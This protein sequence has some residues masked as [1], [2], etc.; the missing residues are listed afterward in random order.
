[1]E[2]KKANMRIEKTLFRSMLFLILL[3]HAVTASWGAITNQTVVL[4]SD[5]NGDGIAGIGDTITFTCRSTTAD[6]TQYPYVNLSQFGNPYFA[7]P[8]IAGTFY[9]AFL[10]ISPG[11]LENNTVQ[12]FQFA[13]EDGVRIGGSLLVDN[14]RPN[15]LYGPSSTGET[16]LGSVFK[17][18]DSLQI[19][20]EMSS[21]FDSDA[22]RANLTNIGL[23]ASHMF[24]RIGGPDSAPVYRL[25]LPFPL[26]REGVATPISV[27]STDDAGNSRSW[28]LSVSYDTKEPEIESVTAVNMTTGKTWVTSGDTIR[29]QA[30]VGNYDFDK[31]KMFHPTLAPAGITMIKVSG[32]TP[33]LQAVYQY[34]YYL[35]DVPDIQ[36]NFVTFEVRSTDDAGNESS[37]RT[38]N[39]LALDNIPP[40]FALPFGVR[41]V[42]NG[43]ILGDNI[44]IIN[45]QLHFVGNLS[46]LMTDVLVTVDLSSIGGVPNQ[47]IP[48]NNSATT[49]F[50][51]LYNVGQYT[52]ENSMPRAFT[53]SA[54]DTAGN[55]IS[56]IILPIIYVDN[57]PPIMTGGQIQNVSRPG[58]IVRHGDQVAITSSVTNLD[59]GNVWVNFE[60]I[61]GS[62]VSALTPYSGT[63]YRLDHVV[64]DPT[65]GNIY[66][67]SVSFTIFATDDSGN[68]VQVIAPNIQIDNEPPLI[69]GS[70][71]SSNPVISL[72]HPYVRVGDSINFRVQL[73]S[74]S[75]S[76]HDQETVSMNL[77]QF[78]EI[79][80]TPMVYDGV[81]SYTLSVTVPAGTLNEEYYFP[82]TATDNAGNSR[83]GTI[84]VKIDNSPPIVGPMAINF[85]TDMSK[86][87]A[88]N[89]GDRLEMIVPVNEPDNGTCTIDLSYI[90]GPSAYIMNYDAVLRRYYLVHDCV[91]SAMENPS[92]VFR[93]I[94]ADKAGNTMNSVSSTF[95]VDCR[96]PVIEYA[97][98]THLELK[99]KP[100]VVNIGDKVRINAK[101]DLGRLDGGIPSV[102][103][104][105]LG[106][107]GV[108]Q[109]FDDGANNDGIAG[110]GLYGYTFTAISGTT[111]GE[112]L[113]FTVQVTDNAG[114]RAIKG[115]EA[116]FIDNKPLTITSITNTQIF[117]N[118]GNSIV[119]LDGVYTTSPVVATDVVR[120]EVWISGNPGD[121]GTLTV[122][123][124][125]LGINNT[126]VQVPYTAISGGWKA[127]ADYTPLTGTTNREEVKLNTTL[128]DVNGNEI[129]MT[130]TNAITVDNR[131]PKID[132]YPISFVVDNGR[133]N[134]GNLGDVVQ[135]KVRLT[136]HNDL[137][138]QI[139]WTNLYLANGLTPPSPTLMLPSAT[140]SN[141][142]V[143]QWT[144]PE[145]LGTVGSLTILA[146]DESGNMAFSYTNEIRFLSKTPVFAGFPQTRADL[147]SDLVPTDTPNGIANPGDQVT[148]TCVLTSLYNTTNA[149]AA[150]VLANVRSLINSPADDSASAYFD[151][152]MRTYWVPLTF[153]AFPISGAGNYVY[154]DIFNITAGGVD[155]D[156]ASFA[157]K[158][159][160]PD[161][162]S[163]V[164]ATSTI[165]CDPD[166]SFGIDTEVPFIKNVYFSIVNENGDN[167]ASNSVNVDD[168]LI[169]RA[170]I[171]KLP[172]PGSAT[173][174]LLMPDNITEV[175]R[176]EIYPVSTN[177]WEAQFRV[178]TWTLTGWK[179]MNGVTPRFQVIA[180]DDADN[181]A[182][183][184]GVATFTIDN[185]PPVI[186]D[187][188]LR[189]NDLNQDTGTANVGD[190]ITLGGDNIRPDGIVASLTVA[191]VGDLAGN[192]RAYVDFTPI[193]GTSTYR[194]DQFLLN[195]AYGLPFE[196]ATNTYDLATRTFKIYVMDG[197]GNKTY[198]ERELGIDT[199]RPTL[200][201]ARYDGA[202]IT[203]DFSEAVRPDV[204]QTNLDLIRLG[205]KM[206]HSDIQIANGS[207]ISL[208]PANDFI[209]ELTESSSINI[210]L[211]SATKG[212]IA[213]WGAVNLY[214][215]I[216][217]NTSNGEA[218]PWPNVDWNWPIT[219]DM[220]GNW[221]KPI[222]RTLANFPIT[223]TSTYT[224]R[225]K[226]VTASHNAN[227]PSEKD[228]LYIT[229]D[230]DMDLTSISEVTL[231]NLAIWLNRSNPAD[232][233]SN[234]Y[235]FLTAAASDTIVGLD[236]PRRLKLKLSEQAQDWIAL[237][238]TRAG[239]QFHLQVNGSE[240]EP[241]DPADP[242]PLIR[243]FEGN[244]IMPITYNNAT[245]GTLIPLNTPFSVQNSS[246]D[247]SGTQPILRI[248]FQNTPARK[249]R[250]F[251]DPYK[252]LAETIEL[253]RD[254][255][256]D[257]SRIY[258]HSKADL[259]GS[260]IPLSSTMVDYS[261]FKTM[262]TDYASTT[263]HIPLT[264]EALK[265]ML[266][267]GTSQFYIA[268]SDG[269][270]RDLWSNPNI[271]YPVQ[272]N[273]AEPVNPIT[274]PA[275]IAQPKIQ[276]IAISPAKSLSAQNIQLFKGQPVGNFFYE[277]AFETAT[278][279]ADVYI[280]IDRTKTPILELF[281][282]DD[283]GFTAPKDTA[284]FVTWLDHNQGGVTRTVARFAN[285]SDLTASQNVQ[286]QPSLVRV[287][288]FADVFSPTTYSETA[289][290][291]Y[292]LNDKDT[293][294]NGFKNASY[295]MVFDNQ[296]PTPVTA[297]PNGTVGITP[298]GSMLFEVTFD[299][300]MDNTVGST[301]QPQLRLGDTANTVMSFTFQSWVS[302][303]TA[304]FVNSANFDAN[305]QQGT[306]TYFVSGGFDEAGNRGL[307]EVQLASQLQIRSKGPNVNSFR[308]TTYQLTTAKFSSPTGDLT[309]APFSPYVP[310][311]IATISID[312]LS[313]PNAS[314][315]W[316]HF[317]QGEASLASIPITLTGLDGKA[318]WDGTF[319]GVPIGLT[320]PTTYNLRVYDDA[321]N[322][323]SKRGNI[324]YDG[325]APEVS[326]W[327]FS[328]VK[329]FNNK[330]YFS[331]TISSFAKIDVFGPSS[332]QALKMR[333]VNPGLATD[334]YPMTS[335][336]GGG[337][338]ISFDGK[339]TDVPAGTLV[340][341]EYAVH[342]VDQAGNVGIPLGANGKA[343]S[344]LVIDRTAPTIDS[345]LMERVDNSAVVTRFNPRVT[346]LKFLVASTD[347]TVAS[348]T[349]L[350]KIKAGSTLIR[351]IILEEAAS[352]FTAIWNGQDSNLQPVPDG[353][354]RVTITDLAGNE[355]AVSTDVTVVNSVFKLT[356]VT[357]KDSSTI[358]VSF[359]HDV[360]PAD[361][362]NVALYTLTPGTPAGIGAGA[363]ITVDG[364]KVTVPLTQ[365]LNHGTL[366]TLTLTPGF[367]SVDDEP[368][369]A[370]NN[371]A[372]F[373]ADT[374]GPRL[375]NITYDGLNSQKK[376]N[377]VFDEQ[378]ESIS[379]QQVGNF[380][381]TTGTETVAIESV[382]LRADLKSVTITSFDD[383]VE[384]KNYT[385]VA[386]GVKDLFGNLSDGA[387]ARLTFQGKDITPPVLI[388]SAFSNPAN[389]FDISV[390]VKANEDLSGAP[391]ATITQSGGTAVSLIL[392][393]GPN[394]RIFIGGAHL[395]PNYPGVATIKV[396][397]RDISTNLGTANMSFSTAYINASI[398]AEIKSP[399]SRFMAVFEPGTLNKNTLVSLLPEQLSKVTSASIKASRILPST[400][401]DVSFEQLKSLRASVTEENDNS[402]DEL[403]P[404]GQAYTLSVP[405]ARIAKPVRMSIKL[406][407]EQVGAGIGLYRS[408]VNGW[409]P[410][411]FEFSDG[412]AN[413]A[414]TSAGTF[415]MMKDTK[416][417]RASMLTA[418]GTEPI[419]EARP[420]FSWKLEEY[421]SGIDYDSALVI[422]NGRVMPL[423]IDQSGTTAKFV[424]VDELV[425]G[426]HEIS[427]KIAD[428]AGNQTI[429]PALR[430][431]AAPPL[432][433][434]E[435]VQFPNP[436]RNRVSLRISTNRPEVDWGEIEVN[437]YDVAG[438]KVAD[439]NNLS[440]R[441]GTNGVFKVQDVIW[442]LKASGGKSVAN[443][444]YFAKI[445][446][447]DPDDWNRKT[448]YNHKIAVLR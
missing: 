356:G 297:V 378:I 60:R 151:G 371:T 442:D 5:L 122:D 18:G 415:A 182:S 131:P 210:M 127:T 4:S 358:T 215:S 404:V 143:Y 62:D 318:S 383:V 117:D 49:T 443:G 173:A 23:G 72:T 359:S 231:G 31:V 186:T 426:E 274:F 159:L 347:P 9:S 141:E 385:I 280:P 319:N 441:T 177:I 444:V 420:T 86:S 95:E 19:D 188:S 135:I 294:V 56:Q 437:I 343:S 55:L 278:L 284:Q 397:G 87:G 22:P 8:N 165:Y 435:I 298:A 312:F 197:A 384:T 35:A 314:S 248:G 387:V 414:T 166:N 193:G 238:Y 34:D 63:T 100:G 407:P 65:F 149:P 368:M 247:L 332:G 61:G 348:G 187:A 96:P 158:V 146:Y 126:A 94:V 125:K 89:I 409:K 411:S 103:L 160:H 147:S 38:S 251:L 447:R 162:S 292:N 51:L 336:T 206:D 307:N 295:T 26:N 136:H 161:A 167:I 448:R 395:D 370:G 6:Q 381:L 349:A 320:G 88:V 221:L 190:G 325:R 45:D 410:V 216:A 183:K 305:T 200:T 194:L 239:S 303:T 235:R 54:K 157:V 346:S 373:T 134:E 242:E 256:V 225:P 424:P 195:T 132:M 211:S 214:V 345:I 429:T 315:L 249:A 342:L 263:A 283:V 101:L 311:S 85:L 439:N 323:G 417:P 66:D 331:P 299:E 341:G 396:T 271:R 199:T 425:G 388:I 174:I 128:T 337:Y 224:V 68:R 354:Y 258:L 366:Y 184:Y 153:Q 83:A 438:H 269:A 416:S 133:L 445:T 433:I 418:I 36:S 399:D 255:P 24:S 316:L 145:G 21:S 205:N 110:D 3:L 259:S 419:R 7:L 129:V 357:Q 330:A 138:P 291:A 156:I 154:R 52:S 270:F 234:R 123:L 204:L 301:W 25:S 432:K 77:T 233:Y 363:P 140:I 230:K 322:E 308:V 306:Y 282:Q 262:N 279:S 275:L 212:H 289:S 309:D 16:G 78:G 296:P 181:F 327:K 392:N 14:R 47:I 208:D 324:V 374:Q 70:A 386:S 253:S 108:Q 114:N 64:G 390:A 30:V 202:V 75:A 164:L 252:N 382:T 105:A 57:N 369:T 328:N 27:R 137:L 192:G 13:D 222:A 376:F 240:Y 1:M 10:T 73:A 422:L 28:D 232:T 406:S 223:V 393:A 219:R 121:M 285:N 11:S 364:N 92:Y 326:Y 375:T 339:N 264:A 67:Q 273:L 175:F 333:L 59:N 237:N 112:T 139:E 281:T 196:L 172:D 155:A 355:S 277:V 268:I 304:R 179:E 338:T 430:F 84:R 144:I 228:F 111:D 440:M 97:S 260:S 213:D 344:T 124:T 403:V 408:D 217:H 80:L 148:L 423:M 152:D 302:A 236:T 33:G 244:R 372:Q 171:E 203:L 207:A 74:S 352:P 360:N 37:P 431:V 350:V 17:I 81:G 98:A 69:A 229:F 191:N 436:A 379:S 377:V 361:A 293:S 180:S 198:V 169:F 118:N 91:E 71:F 340:D 400:M 313:A 362:T 286:R 266:S 351:E 218:L 353:V 243:D 150:T 427:L 428:K 40:E 44:A 109:L 32:N 104:T 189:I 254:L 367:R 241:P 82:F 116:L 102:N 412:T 41:I 267:W 39:P 163:I 99:G 401:A 250:L 58:Q 226:I 115:T 265:T 142:Y 2:I 287:R 20:I 201:M 46:S 365:T 220:S 53:V 391:T 290:L 321:G 50:E 446:L 79:A 42:E 257:L 335:L 300:R 334:T 245:A 120:L 405:A 434:Q 389:E 185:S 380:I 130:T 394:N 119:D 227:T 421:A 48:F 113:A 178:A 176:T 413:F 106:G 398:R 107:S 43:G 12:T 288:N 329:T 209:M 76:V 402:A 168:L 317:Y 276:T 310:S 246:L 272:G 29:I 93:A 170:N 15:S 90:G 261:V